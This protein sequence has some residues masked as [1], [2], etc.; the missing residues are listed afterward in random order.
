M[1][2]S[3]KCKFQQKRNDRDYAINIKLFSP[4]C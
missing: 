1:V 4:V 2:K 3:L